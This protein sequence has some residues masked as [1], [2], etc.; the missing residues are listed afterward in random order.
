MST[1]EKKSALRRAIL[2]R[3]NENPRFLS[4]PHELAKFLENDPRDTADAIKYLAGHGYVE[5][6]GENPASATGLTRITSDGIDL[7]EDPDE[8]NRL[9]PPIQQ[10]VIVQGDLS[11]NVQGS[12]SIQGDTT[13]I[14][15]EVFFSTLQEKIE[16]SDLPADEKR[17]LLD[18]IKSLSSHPLVVG[19]LPTII[20]NLFK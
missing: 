8:F 1:T 19:S 6:K 20:G 10:T 18:S 5:I 11:G 16:A 2:E 12:G 3:L 7:V 14:N 4:R 13:N 9:M 17:T 15:V